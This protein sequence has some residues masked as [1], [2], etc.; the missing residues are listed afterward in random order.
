[1]TNSFQEIHV[2]F[3]QLLPENEFEYQNREDRKWIEIMKMLA[4]NPLFIGACFADACWKGNIFLMINEVPFLL[5][6]EY[7][8]TPTETG[9]SVL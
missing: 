7:G 1:M 2:L 5:K 8:C 6:H 9:Q 4:K 3:V